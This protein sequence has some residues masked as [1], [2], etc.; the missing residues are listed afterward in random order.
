[1]ER[2]RQSSITGLVTAGRILT[3]I[4]HHK[5]KRTTSLNQQCIF[6][7]WLAE[8][9][10]YPPSSPKDSHNMGFDDDGDRKKERKKR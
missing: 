1:M 2:V 9:E 8:L 7:M 3:I 6:A 4:K 10:V 5:E